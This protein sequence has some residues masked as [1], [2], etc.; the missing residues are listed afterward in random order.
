[1]NLNSNDHMYLVATILDSTFLEVR[2]PDS[3]ASTLSNT[4][5]CLYYITFP[6]KKVL[7]GQGGGMSG[8]IRVGTA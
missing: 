2:S 4:Q 6:D 8:A 5:H 7:V 1:M 3:Q